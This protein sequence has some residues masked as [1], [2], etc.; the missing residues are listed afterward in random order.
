[1]YAASP[2]IIITDIFCAVISLTFFVTACYSVRLY[3]RCLAFLLSRVFRLF[4]LSGFL[5]KETTV[6]LELSFLEDG[7][8]RFPGVVWS[9][10]FVTPRRGWGKPGL[11]LHGRLAQVCPRP[12]LGSIVGQPWDRWR[13]RG[14]FSLL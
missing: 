1:M 14:G 10:V 3:H 13:E 9:W 11:G 12:A 2:P 5:T 6:I 4:V 7:I 8:F